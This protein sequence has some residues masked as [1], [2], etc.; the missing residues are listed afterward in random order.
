MSPKKLSFLCVAISISLTSH[1]QNTLQLQIEELAKSTS[2]NLGV[3]ATIIETGEAVSYNDDKHFPMQSVYKFPIAMAVLDKVDRG[4]LKLDTIIHVD[5]ADYIPLGGHSPI[6]DKFPD[7]VAM[8]LSEL[9]E[10]NVV[11]SDGTACD[12]LLR[13]VGGTDA[14]NKYIHK[15]GIKD[16]AIATTEMVQVANDTIQY[17]NWVTPKAMSNL[18]RIFYTKDILS[19]ESK[20]LLLK[21][22]TDSPTGPKRLKGLLPTGT[23]VAHKTG[24]SGTYNDL[25]RATN[26]VGIITL[27]NGKHLAISVFLSD[28]YAERIERELIIAK[29]AKACYD[30]WVRYSD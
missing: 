27:P 16:I 10:Y 18:L 30:F 5:K 19:K 3:Y 20:A 23:R 4:K 6:R 8:K 13:L 2:G 12:V 1:G 9:V 11:Q 25:T 14:A 7:G 21:L 26:D 28:S 17:R 22:M 24:S 29:V 15:L